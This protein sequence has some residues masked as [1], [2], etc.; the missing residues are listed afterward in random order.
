VENLALMLKSFSGDFELAKR[1]IYSF[2]QFNIEGLNLFLVVPESDASQFSELAGAKVT[3]VSEQPIESYFVH[4]SV[5]GIRPGYI[6]QEIV[7]L[8]FWELNLAQNYL[9]VDSDAEFIRPFTESD[10]MFDASTPFS[11]LVQDLEL[12]VEPEYFT[13]YWR[14]RSEQL[15]KIADYVGLD[16]RVIL[17]CHGHT[18]FSA[19]I[20]KDFKDSFLTPRGWS[21]ADALEVAPY[22]FSWYNMW[23]QKCQLIDI[24]PREPWFKVFHHENQH[25]EYV[26]RGI[27]LA[28]IARGYLGVVVNSSFAREFDAQPAGASKP[29]TL[30]PYLSYGELGA[31]AG[32]KISNSLKRIFR[33]N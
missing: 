23:L 22:E 15:I 13:Q 20:L 12:A 31:L 9:C 21:Y 24:H 17:T 19:K 6:N 7:K 18:V 27:T 11:V 10:F 25:L 29:A 5:N 33:S 8:G 2:N 32:N 26:M 28:D 4:E 14:S 1:C 16:S 3:I 30:A